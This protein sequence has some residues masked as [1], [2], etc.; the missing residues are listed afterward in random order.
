MNRSAALFFI[1][2]TNALPPATASSAEPQVPE[3]KIRSAIRRS[4]PYLEEKGRWW[5]DEKKCTSCHRVTFLVWSLIEADRRGFPLDRK[6]LDGWI[7]WSLKTPDKNSPDT[8]A[9]L[10]LGVKPAATSKPRRDR[11]AELS[12]KLVSLQQPDGSWKPGGQLPRQKRPLPETAQVSTMW[13]VAALL[14]HS[15]ETAVVRRK[16]RAFLSSSKPGKSTEWYAARI[17]LEHRRADKPAVAKWRK[18]L[19]EQQHADGGWG[20]LTAEKSDALAAGLGL[21]ALL[22]TGT[23]RRHPAV[24]KA[25]RFLIDSQQAN[26]RWRVNGTKAGKRDKPQETSNY[27]GTAWATIGLLQLLPEKTRSAKRPR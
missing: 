22:K 8:L 2:L 3:G 10:I 16:A 21:Y 15:G 13:N 19:L 7:D 11:L 5:I 25:A 17:L 23:P 1:V 14:S 27:W 24:Q 9:Q 20:W 26:G 18:L 12:D 4:L 6:K